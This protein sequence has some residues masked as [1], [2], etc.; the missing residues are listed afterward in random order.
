MI[1]LIFSPNSI[2]KYLEMVVAGRMQYTLVAL[3]AQ[4][5]LK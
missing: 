5:T 3:S 1:L 2:D 4:L